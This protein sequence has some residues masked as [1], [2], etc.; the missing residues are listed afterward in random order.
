MAVLPVRHLLMQSL[1]G[2]HEGV[3]SIL[4]T[5]IF[6]SGGSRNLSMDK[7]ARVIQILGYLHQ[8]PA[9]ITSNA[10]AAQMMLRALHHYTKQA[11]GVTTRQEIGIFD[12]QA[13]HWEFRVSTDLGVTWTFVSDFGPT[14]VNTIPDFAQVGNLLFMTN[15]ISS[16]QQWDG[17]VLGTAGGTQLAAPGY[18]KT[19]AGNLSGNVAFRVVPMIGSVRKLSSIQSVNFPVNLETGNVTWVADPD[20]TVTGYEVYR[21]TG[22]G[23]AFYLDGSVVGRLTVTFVTN[24]LDI[25]LIIGRVLQEYGDPPPLGARFCED[26]KQRVWYIGTNASPRTA[27]FSDPGLPASVYIAQNFI[28]CT[29][30]ESWSD[31]AVGGTGGFGG[32][33]VIWLERSIWVISGTGVLSGAVVDWVRRRTDAQ[34]GTVH[35]RTVARIP[36][37]AVYTNEKGD[38]VRTS[39]VTL[40]YLTPLSDIRIFDGNNDTIISHPKRATLSTMG[41]A[42]R[43]K[44]F[45]IHDR[46]RQEVAWI[47][48][49]GVA[50]EPSTAVV[51]NYRHGVWFSRDWPFAC[52]LEVES[53]N[54]SSV[55]L[56]GSTLQIPGVGATCYQLWTGFTFDGGPINSQWMTKTLYGIGSFYDPT[57]YYG[58]PL[59]SMRK[60]WR[61]ADLLVNVAGGGVTFIIEWIVGDN[62]ADGAVALGSSQF[63][64]PGSTLAD[65]QG[66]IIEDAGGNILRVSADGA[67]IRTKLQ[68]ALG[69][70]AHSR[71]LRLRIRATTVVSQW[72][73]S[74]IDVGYQL[75][76]GQ[77]REIGTIP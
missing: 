17:T 60:R 61:W 29:D 39:A 33:L 22:S 34:I 15:G 54:S 20:V 19:G 16:P 41:Y 56:A 53:S 9:A 30:A 32:L 5:E 72:S 12:S 35:H 4:L 68:D 28:D 64:I 49:D 36:A 24:Q 23:S 46:T 66:N 47:Y 6:S 71:G 51:W 73:L 50:L 44:A 62:Q 69:R 74:G 45:C 26:H 31:N 2:D 27:W 63:Q 70:Y 18:A 38:V 42:E 77:T 48:A 59:I 25:N 21:T 40:A 67:L 8:N 58:K 57:G 75:L 3:E 43:S 13:T 7:E 37:G 55:L 65:A 1:D 14:C 10:G 76:P 11:G 52:G